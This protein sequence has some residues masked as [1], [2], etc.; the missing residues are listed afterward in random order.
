MSRPNQDDIDN[1]HRLC[2]DFPGIGPSTVSKLFKECGF[3]Y[4]KTRSI[5]EG[6]LQY[7]DWQDEYYEDDEREFGEED[8]NAYVDEDPGLDDPLDMPI[9]YLTQQYIS[10]GKIHENP[11]KMDEAR[12]IMANEL[13]A[14]ENRAPKDHLPSSDS[15]CRSWLQA[16]FCDDPECS[17][18]H[19]L[20]GVLCPEDLCV[21]DHCVLVHKSI[22]DQ[23][24]KARE[25]LGIEIQ[26]PDE[27]PSK[28]ARAAF[29]AFNAVK[30]PP[31]EKLREAFPGETIPDD[32]TEVEQCWW[33]ET[34]T[35][36]DVELA[37]KLEEEDKASGE[38]IL[39]DKDWCEEAVAGKEC[40][41]PKY[42]ALGHV[43]KSKFPFVE[44]FRAYYNEIE[45]HGRM[46]LFHCDAALKCTGEEAQK[47]LNLARI[48]YNRERYL[49][50]LCPEYH[51][52]MGNAHYGVF[53][54]TKERVLYLYDLT[55]VETREM[56]RQLFEGKE[57]QQLHFFVFCMLSREK[58]FHFVT[59]DDIRKY[60]DNK[61]IKYIDH[62]GF[63]E[64]VF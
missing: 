57:R 21:N 40:H 37:K 63:L 35:P 39:I 59:I 33:P 58:Y 36:K 15:V 41:D 5:L 43:W 14:I 51:L 54:D 47:H 64:F 34:E 16:G 25:K 32:F 11:E 44:K 24:I 46:R 2:V 45:I 61:G 10:C 19:T 62:D 27:P 31:V 9:E 30:C 22:A 6:M 17:L 52:H 38:W 20:Y 1:Y 48:H 8:R 18:L 29:D 50:R 23:L 3:D 26:R 4:P 55:V 49:N 42:F 56:L 12:P 13:D 7:E 28:F 53:D 60:C